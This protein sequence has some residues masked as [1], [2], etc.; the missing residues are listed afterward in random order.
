MSA[1]VLDEYDLVAISQLF[2]QQQGKRKSVLQP[3]GDGAGELPER[4]RVSLQ[5]IDDHPRE[6]KERFFIKTYQV[7][8]I[9]R[10]TGFLEAEIDRLQRQVRIMFDPVEPLFFGSSDHDTVLDHTRGSIM[11]KTG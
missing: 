6:F 1:M 10:D 7:D 5:V 11:I 3:A 2:F 8:I 4:E 9:D